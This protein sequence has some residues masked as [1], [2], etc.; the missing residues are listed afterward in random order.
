MTHSLK[1]STQDNGENFFYPKSVH[2]EP[3]PLSQACPLP[4][5]I[6]VVQQTNICSPGTGPQ[7]WEYRCRAGLFADRTQDRW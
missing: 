1:I 5:L 2:T 3:D 7:C 6:T 4:F